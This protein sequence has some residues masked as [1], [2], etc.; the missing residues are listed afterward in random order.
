MVV[1]DAMAVWYF[2]YPDLVVKVF[3]EK[4]GAFA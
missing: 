1:I 3:F 2:V 4:E